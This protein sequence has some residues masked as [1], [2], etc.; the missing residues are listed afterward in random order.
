MALIRTEKDLEIRKIGFRDDDILAAGIS[1]PAEEQQRRQVL[2]DINTGIL[3]AELRVARAEY[4]AA[5]AEL[6]RIVLMLGDTIVQAPIDGIVGMRFVEAGEKAG[7]DTLLFTLFNTDR[8]YAQIE[9]AEADL[10]RLQIGQEADLLFEGDLH[11]NTS[12]QLELIS[13]YINP[14]T[15]TARVRISIENPGGALVPGMFVQVRIFTGTAEQ[16][17]TIP[18]SAAV[19]MPDIPSPDS[20]VVYI[21]RASHLFRQEVQIG[22]QEGEDVVVLEGL[23]PGEAVVLDASPGLADGTEVEVLP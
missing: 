10:R 17:V 5:S 11:T 16:Q 22:H 19:P 20:A 4:E 15:R 21:V 8:V 18:R 3:A 9:V 7:R 6:R 23:A 12:G 13:P 2:T 1:I 14:K